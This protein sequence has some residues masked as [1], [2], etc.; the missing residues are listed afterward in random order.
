ML[1]VCLDPGHGG[2]DPGATKRGIIERDW[3]L[4]F[5]KEL[6]SQFDELGIQ[7]V[8]TRTTNDVKPSFASRG[9]I[10][11]EF[12]SDVTLVIHVNANKSPLAR[13]LTTYHLL[14]HK[15][16]A[17]MGTQIMNTAPGGLARP[18]GKSIEAHNGPGLHDD[19]LQAPVNVLTP[20]GSHSTAL[21]IETFFCSNATDVDIVSQPGLVG[22]LAS[23]IVGVVVEH[24]V[25]LCTS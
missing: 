2:N 12:K 11:Q 8:L 13:G 1:K 23:T 5:C 7:T 3:N 22:K 24:H 19:W 16:A 20:H 15:T 6:E 14:G 4:M 21:L 25:F 18:R 17:A 10:S 9:R